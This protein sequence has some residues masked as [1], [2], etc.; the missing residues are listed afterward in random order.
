[1]QFVDFYP[2]CPLMSQTLEGAVL[3]IPLAE[4]YDLSYDFMTEEQRSLIREE[5]I[6]SAAQ[7]KDQIRDQ[8]GDDGLWPAGVRL[9]CPT[10]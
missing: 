4:S 5:L 10:G 2:R 6:W 8:H 1:M 9:S 3:M 7:F